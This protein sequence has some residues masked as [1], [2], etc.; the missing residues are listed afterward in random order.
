MLVLPL[1]DSG[2]DVGDVSTGSIDH[3][4]GAVHRMAGEHVLHGSRLKTAQSVAAGVA[5][6]MPILLEGPAAVGKTSLVAAMAR[7]LPGGP[8]RLERVNNTESTSMQ[9]CTAQW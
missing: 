7:H 3:L 9:V 6:G 4:Q 1:Q 5:M 2:V 8:F